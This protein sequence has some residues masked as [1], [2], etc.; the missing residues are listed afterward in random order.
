MRGLWVL[1][2]LPG[3]FY[4]SGLLDQKKNKLEDDLNQEGSEL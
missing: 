1:A 2:S 4:I 3:A